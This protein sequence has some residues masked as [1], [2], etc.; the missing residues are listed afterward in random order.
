MSYSIYMWTNSIS[1]KSYIGASK[2]VEARWKKH[3]YDAHHKSALPFHRALVKYDV[4]S[5]AGSILRSDL[6]LDEAIIQETN[7]I[8]EHNTQSPAGYNLTLGGR[9][10]CNHTFSQ[11]HR[12]RLKWTD[13]RRQLV[14]EKY[15]NGLHP[16][17]GKLS[18]LRGVLR[19]DTTKRFSKDWIVIT[20]TGETLNINNLKAFCRSHNLNTGHMASVAKGRLH[21]HKGYMCVEKT[22]DL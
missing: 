15:R 1:K 16:A 8:V 2:N 22:C 6:S 21:A 19:P 13:E 18:K 3:L 11:T 5:W 4:A 20:P 17:K 12:E 7:C 9:G 10:L 14:F